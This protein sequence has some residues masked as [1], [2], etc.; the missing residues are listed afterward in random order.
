M[1]NDKARTIVMHEAPTP[2]D[3]A[4]TAA[5]L[6]QL[7]PPGVNLGRRFPLDRRELLVGRE[8]EVDILLE[9]ASVSRRQ[10]KLFQAVGSWFVEDLSSTNG[11]FVNEQRVKTSVL[12][13]NDLVRFGEVIL[14]FLVGSNIEAAYHEEIYRVSIQDGLT[15][16]HNKRYFLEFLEREI[17][18]TLRYGT[19]L[20]LLMFDIDH[21][22]RVNDTFGHLAGDAVLKELGRRL[23]PRM[24]ATDLLARYGGEEFAVV[25]P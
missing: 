3:S 1:S 12:Q 19:P 8:G 7:H 23:Q 9:V 15:G 10:A 24:R 22:K 21:F 6:V 20:A 17:S 13:T 16:T 25:L 14:K 5:A 11:T 2:A 4:G 18:R